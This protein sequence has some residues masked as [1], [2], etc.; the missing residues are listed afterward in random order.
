MEMGLR[1]LT[2]AAG[3]IAMLASIY[4]TAAGAQV[5]GDFIEDLFER[6]LK[7]LIEQCVDTNCLNNPGASAGSWRVTGL[8]AGQ[9]LSMFNSPNPNT[10]IVGRGRRNSYSGFC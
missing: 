9:A 5:G 3:A 10:A 6:Q 7:E 8:M 2:S 1:K 4:A